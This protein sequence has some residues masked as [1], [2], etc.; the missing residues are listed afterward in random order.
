MASPN[1]TYDDV[2]TTTIE[3]RS[4]TLRDNFSNNTALLFKLKQKGRQRTFSGGRVITEELAFAGPGNFQ[5]YSGYDQIGTSQADMLTAAEFNI[6]QA[7]VA[8]SM[9]GLEM[10]QNAG[11]DAFIDLF[12]SRLEQAERELVNN[13]SDGIYSDGTGSGGKQVGGLQ[14]LIADTGLGTVGGIDSSAY[15]WWQNQIY[16]FSTE[17]ATPG[18]ST[19]QA[20]MNALWLRCSRNRD[21]PDL[22]MADD[23]YYTYYWSSLQAIQRITDTSLGEAGF[24]NLKFKSAAVVFDGGI[25][26]SAPSSHMYFLNSDYLYWRPHSARNMVPLN[27]DRYSM[28]QDAFVRLIAWAGNMTT[29]GRQFQGVIV[30]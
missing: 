17:G 29:A 19:I 30:A 26:G 22:I 13:L 11:P 16:D 5:Y 8:V 24:D 10:L 23:T 6:K 14:L 28:N 9:S 2:A 25:N 12:A 7:V 3:H 20:A 18:P 15:S 4:R 1:S 27:P 21:Q